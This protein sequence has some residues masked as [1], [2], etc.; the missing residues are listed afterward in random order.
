MRACASVL[1]LLVLIGA[2]AADDSEPGAGKDVIT[3]TKDNFE[4]EVLKTNDLVLVEFYAPWCGHCKS[5]APEWAK[6]ATALKGQGVKLVA[7]DATKESDL[8]QTYKAQGY[9]TLKSFPF[10]KK[11]PEVEGPECEDDPEFECGGWDEA[12]CKEKG[13]EEENFLTANQACCVCGGGMQRPTPEPI[14]NDYHGGRT[15]DDIIDWSFGE[16]EKAGVNL[17]LP[18]LVDREAFENK[19]LNKKYCVVAVLPHLYDSGA[20]GRRQ[21]IDVLSTVA[22][23]MRQLA[24]F[25]WVQG[26]NQ[27][28]LETA[29]KMSSGYPAV[30]AINKD[31]KRYAVHTGSFQPAALSKTLRSMQTGRLAT[32]TYEEVP[33]ISATDAWDGGEYKVAEEEDEY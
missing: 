17:T 7:V 32:N 9:P 26:G 4:E 22:K 6:A 25:M 33:K 19:C 21:H 3:G 28:A 24:S 30:V 8:A 18:E 10:G 31:R 20:A 2:A 11:L 16:L 1:P 14:V 29:F 15:A 12:K 23:S 5:L 27:E 13:D